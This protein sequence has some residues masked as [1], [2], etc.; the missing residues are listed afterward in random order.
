M[1]EYVLVC[2]ICLSIM[3]VFHVCAFYE[4]VYFIMCVYF[5][6]VNGSLGWPIQSITIHDNIFIEEVI[7]SNSKKVRHMCVWLVVL[8]EIQIQYYDN[9]LIAQ[10][11]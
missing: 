7:Y 5:I 4:G 8:A 1:Y 3:C 9:I 11:P 6:C 10:T 2:A